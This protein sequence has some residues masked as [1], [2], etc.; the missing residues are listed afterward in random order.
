M[1]TLHIGDR[2]HQLVLALRETVGPVEFRADIDAPFFYS[3]DDKR[4]VV[5][6]WLMT[7]KVADIDDDLFA[8]YVKAAAVALR[9]FA[10]FAEHPALS[11]VAFQYT[12]DTIDIWL[13]ELSLCNDLLH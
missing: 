9:I 12:K 7:A 1:T 13:S 2:E 6:P 10:T 4:L 3:G 8:I 11:E 5:S